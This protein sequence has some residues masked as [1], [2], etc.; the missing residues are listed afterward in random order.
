MK[1]LSEILSRQVQSE[2]KRTIEALQ[3]KAKLQER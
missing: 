1:N 2:G 3:A